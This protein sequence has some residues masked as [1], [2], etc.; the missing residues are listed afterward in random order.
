MFQ[1]HDPGRLLDGDL[2]LILIDRYP[3]DPDLSWAPSYRFVMTLAGQSTPLGRID[4][5]IGHTRHILMYAGH[6]GYEVVPAYRG[7]HYAARACRLLFPLARSHGLNPLWITCNP[8]NWP[9]RRTCELAGGKLVEIIDLPQD[10]DMY[11]KGERRK[12]RYRI[13]L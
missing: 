3:G 5:R 9:S 6:I 8:N 12:C 10:T 4:L 2:E 1:F 11:R 7:H 13:D